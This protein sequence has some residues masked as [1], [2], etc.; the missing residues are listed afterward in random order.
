[1]IE[2]S[3]D[4]RLKSVQRERTSMEKYA[5]VKQA[6]LRLLSMFGS[7]YICESVLSTLKHVNSKHCAVLTDTSERIAASS[8]S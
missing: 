8:H 2:F 5:N 7:N 6:A 4:E 1:M 3:E